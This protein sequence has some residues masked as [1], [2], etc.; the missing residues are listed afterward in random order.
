MHNVP[1]ESKWHPFGHSQCTALLKAD[2]VVD[3]NNL[4]IGQVDK[5]IVQVAI[6]QTFKINLINLISFCLP[7]SAPSIE[8]TAAVRANRCVCSHQAD[9]VPACIQS[10]LN[11]SK[12]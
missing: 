10:S 2:I 12:N 3:M 7:M 1:G 11:I 6:T 4:P 5:H 8:L 9:E